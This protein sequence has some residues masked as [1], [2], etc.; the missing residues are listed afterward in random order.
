MANVAITYYDAIPD[1]NAFNSK[2]S[3]SGLVEGDTIATLRT[4]NASFDT[5]YTVGSNAG[6]YE[7]VVNGYSNN[8]YN[9]T[10][11]NGTLTVNKRALTISLQNDYLIYGDEYVPSFRYVGFVGNDTAENAISGLTVSG[12]TKNAGEHTIIGA[13]ATSSNYEITYVGAKLEIEQRHIYL[14]IHDQTKVYG[15]ENP[16]FTYALTS[17][18]D[19]EP[20]F[21]FDE[22][23]ADLGEMV[24]APKNFAG[25]AGVYDI[26]VN[27]IT[28]TNYVVNVTSAKFTVTRKA[29]TITAK[30]M[31]ITFGDKDPAPYFN[32]VETDGFV[33]GDTIDNVGTQVLYSCAFV[34]NANGKAGTYEIT[35]RLSLDNYIVTAN[36]GTLTV[37]K[38]N[39]TLTGD[40]ID[41]FYGSEKPTLTAKSSYY[42][43]NDTIETIGSFSLSCQY[44][45]GN[46]V[47]D[48]T[49]VVSNASSDKYNITVAN[50]K[51][52]VN[53]YETAVTWVGNNETYTY[54]SE[55]RTGMISATYLDLY[56]EEHVATI[57]FSASNSTPNAFI[58]AG[59]YTV[60]ATSGDSNY[61]LIGTTIKLVMG[62]ASYSA[63]DVV[64]PSG[65]SGVYSPEKTLGANYVIGSSYSWANNSII[66]TVDVTEYDAYYNADTENYVNYPIKVT[67]QITPA[68]VSLSASS[69]TVDT[70]YVVETS[71]NEYATSYTIAPSV[72]WIEGGKTIGAGLYTLT[73]SNGSTFTPGS[74]Y[75]QITFS[76]VNYKMDSTTTT[77]EGNN[78]VTTIDYFIKYKSVDVGGTLYTAEDA[79]NTATSGNVIVKANTSF[80]TSQEAID[81]FYATDA[82]YTVKSGV[83]LLVP[84]KNG[85]TKGYADG[86]EEGSTNYK[87]HPNVTNKESDTPVLFRTLTIPS[88]VT[89]KVNG[90]LTVGALTGT[91]DSGTRQNRISGNYSELY[92]Y[93]N[94]EAN[95]ASLNVYGYIKGTGKIT[96]TGSTV[97]T[98]TMYLTGFLGGSI[99]AGRY[100][101]N[102]FSKSIISFVSSSSIVVDNPNMFP[103]N[104]YAL[105]AI[106]STLELNYGSSLRGMVKIATSAQKVSFVSIKAK[107]NKAYFPIISS[108]SNANSALLRITSQ[109]SKITKSFTPDPNSANVNDPDA[110][111][112]GRVKFTL[113]GDIADGYADLEVAVATT[114]LKMSSQ[115][116]FF[117]ID[118]R[119]DLEVK[120]GTFAQAY[121][122]KLLP[123]ATLTIKSGANHIVNGSIIT[124]KSGFTDTSTYAYPTNRGDAK[125][126]VEGTLTINGKAGGD[127]YGVNGGKVV[128]G[129]NAT[130]ASLKSVEGSGSLNVSTSGAKTTFTE[131]QSQTRNLE[132]HNASGTASVSKGTTYTY[133]GS[134]WG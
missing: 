11:E 95:N 46:D 104:Q 29:L 88:V 75:T 56:G 19:G 42:A 45:K 130:I 78:N 39:I 30:D 34:A 36:K 121:M 98:E 58:N 63:S 72:Y 76:S 96:A 69:S 60:T 116:V 92:L 41:V 117:P 106:Q 59:T 82:Y 52:V 97:V 115:K 110:K 18:V 67:V 10:I 89:L 14:V 55:D 79:L 86:G 128:V 6:E 85:D 87:E 126:Y 44:E 70:A 24:I 61:K 35:P 66:P 1:E 20:V 12:D 74:H 107:I 2:L 73:Y 113:E 21:G 49:I 118:G 37:N 31:T 16:T 105:R 129:S 17:Y 83:T 125:I 100:G 54:N 77:V 103:F 127:V 123:G 53:P 112:K 90:A 134:T 27:G 91:Q 108:S 7:V 57:S 131:S 109:G 111:D 84:Y 51:V 102:D 64:E 124:Y 65:L 8:N 25:N 3:V 48:Y 122:F 81:K 28:N 22:T 26:E 80:A 71:I 5:L 68:L 23:V 40:T 114:K 33:N 13:N 133:N 132:L 38:K 47:G 9:L 32:G 94:I 93:G 119:I 15:E 99:S 43:Y 101:G 50:G 4:Q 120:S 62:K